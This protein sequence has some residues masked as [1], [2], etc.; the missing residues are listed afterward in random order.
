MISKSCQTSANFCTNI[1]Q[2]DD[3]IADSL[4]NHSS[5]PFNQYN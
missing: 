2:K 4:E 5:M 3:V 1:L